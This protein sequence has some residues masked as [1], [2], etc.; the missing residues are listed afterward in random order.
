MKNLVQNT[1]YT[2]NKT[3][4]LKTDNRTLPKWTSMKI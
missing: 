1:L 3:F 4:L 2:R